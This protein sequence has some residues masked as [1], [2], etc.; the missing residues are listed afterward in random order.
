MTTQQTKSK[1]KAKV[2]KVPNTAVYATG[3]RKNA[4]VR[5]WVFKGTGIISINNKDLNDHLKSQTLVEIVLQPLKLLGLEK[6][7]DIVLKVSGGGIV[8]QASASRH[9]ISRALENANDE[10]R[11]PLKAAGFLTRDPRVKER[12]KYGRKKARKGF[13]YRKR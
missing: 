13:Q 6:K 7:Y 3:K 8:G 11:K 9:G 12:K 4:I 2:L 10:H 1:V 5:T